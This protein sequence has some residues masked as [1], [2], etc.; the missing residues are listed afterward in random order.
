[1]QSYCPD[2]LVV[3]LLLLQ[4]LAPD[5][6]KLAELQPKAADAVAAALAAATAAEEFGLV[7]ATQLAAAAAAGSTALSTG[8]S[9]SSS[10]SSTFH[11]SLWQLCSQLGC[12]NMPSELLLPWLQLL[13]SFH[14][15]QSRS[16][17]TEGTAGGKAAVAGQQVEPLAADNRQVVTGI[18]AANGLDKQQQQQRPY[19]RATLHLAGSSSSD[20]HLTAMAAVLGSY[21]LEGSSRH[22]GPLQ[23]LQALLLQHLQQPFDLDKKLDVSQ[24]SLMPWK[25]G[26]EASPQ[27]AAAKAEL[28]LLQLDQQ[29]HQQQQQQQGDRAHQPPLQQ[30]Q[31]PG[32][33]SARCGTTTANG[34]SCRGQWPWP[35][36]QT[37]AAAAAASG[38]RGLP[39]SGGG[40]ALLCCS[41]WLHADRLLAATPLEWQ[42]QL[43]AA[44]AMDCCSV[45]KGMEGW[46]QQQQQQQ[47]L[48]MLAGLNCDWCNQPWARKAG[49]GSSSNAS[50]A[51][52]AAA[53]RQQA[54]YGCAACSAAQY[55]SAECAAAAKKVH[56]P[57]C[58]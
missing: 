46:Q 33:G 31:S 49:S 41:H 6:D 57:N 16:S 23:W 54:P 8:S 24:L 30:Q 34:G 11:P 52:A 51:A 42:Q 43:A 2:H 53:G 39:A 32:P 5:S 26:V 44:A 9:S 15:L 55:C 47:H 22:A 36:R 12:Y 17:M 38:A 7:P 21:N 48:S 10:S 50:A 4:L 27:L 40:G 58:W 1:V 14:A 56:G 37:A 18:A 29:E 20:V 25:L 35:H 13:T 19:R 3:Q 28:L 45:S